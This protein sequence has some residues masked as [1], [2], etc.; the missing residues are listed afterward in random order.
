[1]DHS[2]R[3]QWFLGMIQLGL[4]VNTSAS[5]DHDG[6]IPEPE[7]LLRCAIANID[8]GARLTSIVC[9]HGRTNKLGWSAGQIERQLAQAQDRRPSRRPHEGYVAAPVLYRCVDRHEQDRHARVKFARVQKQNLR[10][11]AARH[12]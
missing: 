4:G 7:G 11:L 9:W 6:D 5:D 8:L 1:M 2:I 10:S 12:E 3:S